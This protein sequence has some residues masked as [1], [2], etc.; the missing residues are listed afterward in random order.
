MITNKMSSSHTNRKSSDSFELKSSVL[1]DKNFSIK[2]SDDYFGD[3]KGKLKFTLFG[4]GISF[5]VKGEDFVYA[6]RCAEFF[7]GITAENLTEYPAL[8]AL[9]EAVGRYIIDL[10]DECGDKWELGDFVFDEDL[11]VT[12]LLKVL[13]PD[14]LVFKRLSGVSEEECPVAFSLKL[15]FDPVPDEVIEIAAHG[16]VPVYAGEYRGVDPWNDRLLKKRWNYIGDK[17]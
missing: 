1:H 15:S 7:E 13:T 5:R 11:A 6:R 3:L 2:E 14:G 17:K 16:D 12:D 8:N 4:C 9:F 10:L